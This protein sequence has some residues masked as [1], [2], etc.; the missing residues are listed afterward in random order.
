MDARSQPALSCWRHGLVCGGRMGQM[1]VD[2]YQL[3]HAGLV[4]GGAG[5][6]GCVWGADEKRAPR[7]RG[8]VRSGLIRGV[9]LDEGDGFYQGSRPVVA[10]ATISEAEEVLTY[11][12]DTATG[13]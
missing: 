9:G 2:R 10:I 6:Y 13:T 5:G 4:G 1:R 3:C 11:V 7:R 12:C 8:V